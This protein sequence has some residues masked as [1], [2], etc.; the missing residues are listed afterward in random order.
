[1]HFYCVSSYWLC[2]E[3][4]SIAYRNYFLCLSYFQREKCF[5]NQVAINNK[6]V[7]QAPS[8]LTLTQKKFLFLTVVIYRYNWKH[9][10]CVM[11]Y[12]HVTFWC[13]Q[14]DIISWE[15]LRRN[16]AVSH[17]VQHHHVAT[18][19]KRWW[20]WS[21][22]VPE[23]KKNPK[24]NSRALWSICIAGRRFSFY[25][26]SKQQHI[27]KCLWTIEISNMNPVSWG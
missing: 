21:S 13:I 4:S 16:A 17:K 2:K 6:G 3:N 25:E 27:H 26:K 5:L 11:T 1:M 23:A 24:L 9:L 14:G 20:N 22:T 10:I 15:A 7:E 19:S 18:T 12:W 8:S